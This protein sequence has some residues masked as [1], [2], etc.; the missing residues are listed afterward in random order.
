MNTN[1]PHFD[2]TN[3]Q[4]TGFNF[5]GTIHSKEGNVTVGKKEYSIN[6]LQEALK[7]SGIT[8]V[9]QILDNQINGGR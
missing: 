8:M 1:G 5:T 2:A 9:T 3:S 4:L 6:E 7:R